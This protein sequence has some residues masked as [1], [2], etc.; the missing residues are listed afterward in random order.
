MEATKTAL[1]NLGDH[2][3]RPLPN[4]L[5]EYGFT[6][7][8][9]IP[10]V[11]RTHHSLR[12][13][14]G[15]PDRILTDAAGWHYGVFLGTEQRLSSIQ[16][17]YPKRWKFPI[18]RPEVTQGYRDREQWVDP[19]SHELMGVLGKA[20]QVVQLH[21]WWVSGLETYP[22]GVRLVMTHGLSQ[23]LI[24]WD[25]RENVIYSYEVGS[26]DKQQHS[27]IEVELLE[28]A[29]H[30]KHGELTQLNKL[31]EFAVFV[32]HDSGIE[33]LDRFR[34]AAKR[35]EAEEGESGL[36]FSPVLTSESRGV[37]RVVAVVREHGQKVL[38][39]DTL[40]WG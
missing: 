40:L 21:K 14:P 36:A 31:G 6:E 33:I 20:L 22:T 8:H 27:A 2:V 13:R 35:Y 4:Q 25:P 16:R 29:P 7:E 19:Q 9:D 28:I 1:V 38:D 34:Q 3:G 37:I 18:N 17:L 10:G 24:G 39:I 11:M 30:R 32:D 5:K 12:G 26:V 23:I 15:F